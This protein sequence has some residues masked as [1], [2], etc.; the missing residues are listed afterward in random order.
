M[1]G[2]EYCTWQSICD[3]YFDMGSKSQKMYL[4]WFPFSR[5]SDQDKQTIRSKDY[6]EKHISSGAFTMYPAVMQRSENY[7][8]KADGSFRDATLISPILY[9]VLQSV[10]KKVS[11]CYSRTNKS[12]ETYYSGNYREMC[13]KYKMDYDAFFKSI[14]S[15]T[16]D[17]QYYI[18]TDITNFFGCINQDILFDRIDDVCNR[19]KTNISQLELSLYKELF[20]YCGNGRFPLIENSLASSYLATIVYLDE[21]DE[22]I[23]RY[24]ADNI[25]CIISFRIIRYVDDMYILFSVDSSEINVQNIYNAIRNE[26]ASILR[27]YGLSLNGKKTRF[28]LTS[29]IGEELKKSL[30]D[31][32]I[33]DDM[34][35]VIELHSDVLIDFLE[36]LNEYVSSCGIC[37]EEYCALIDKHFSIDEL[38]YTADEVFNHFIYDADELLKSSE[39][40]DLIMSII[41]KDISVI[42][43]D[44]KRLSVM[45][46]KTST[47]GVNDKTI[48]AMLNNLFDRNRKGIWNSYDTI[49]AISY[50]TQSK[51]QHIELLTVLKK[52]CKGFHE[53]YDY[54][55][56]RSMIGALNNS[57]INNL[58]DIID[59]DWKAFYLKFLFFVSISKKNY[60]AAYSYYKNYF[61]RVTADI[62]YKAGYMKKKNRPSYN[63]FYRED[64]LIGFY[65]QKIDAGRVARIVEKAQKLRR[66]NPLS[67][68][69]AEMI[70]DNSSSKEIALTIE[71]LELLIHDYIN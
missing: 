44:A 25:E 69:S 59:F 57:R 24:I 16:D 35:E 14:N 43:L 47:S 32:S 12:V 19:A 68:A 4:Q 29:R 13:P 51:F 61:D 60:I 58:C 15:Y 26:Y 70:D 7:I 48:K 9:L 5:L 49:A 21:V 39:V 66:E 42:S 41:N 2:I 33:R 23:S 53:Y 20:S 52:R 37:L 56:R 6:F 38:E 11:E 10:G 27:E 65:S 3:M 71:E 63:S 8:Q 36:D 67:H 30:Y 46:M 17:Y 45:I 62:A 64:N 34:N 54:F 18:K 1:F 50:L 55:C 31:E 22:K 28:G 40:I